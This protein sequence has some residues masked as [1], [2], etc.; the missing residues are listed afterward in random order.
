MKKTPSALAQKVSL[1]H[2]TNKK[3]SFSKKKHIKTF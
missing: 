1:N 2:E 3:K